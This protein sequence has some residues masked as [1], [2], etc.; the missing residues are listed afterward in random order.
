[1]DFPVLGSINRWDWRRDGVDEDCW[2]RNSWSNESWTRS[3]TFPRL[4]F[5]PAD[6]LLRWA[7]RTNYGH[8]YHHSIC[9]RGIW[10]ITLPRSCALMRS[11]LSRF[12]HWPSDRFR[13]ELLQGILFL[14]FPPPWVE[15]TQRPCETELHVWRLTSNDFP[16][17]I[18]RNFKIV[19]KDEWYR[20]R[21]VFHWDRKSVV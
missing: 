2:G 17:Q 14:E 13:F 8:P 7:I 12:F 10:S 1:M 6:W 9:S 16:R 5:H 18:L 21:W 15:Q 20:S 19:S 11:I 3:P 4:G